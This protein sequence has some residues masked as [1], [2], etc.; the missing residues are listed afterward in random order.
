MALTE[1]V[2]ADRA[3]MAEALRNR[4]LFNDHPELR[5]ENLTDFPE[6]VREAFLWMAGRFEATLLELASQIE[7]GTLGAP[8]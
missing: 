1:E 8:R 4:V 7:D 2:R 6:E 3:R 5:P